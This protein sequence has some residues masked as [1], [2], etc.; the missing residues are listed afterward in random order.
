MTPGFAITAWMTFKTGRLRS[1][2]TEEE[3]ENSLAGGVRGQRT[4]NR[5]S[6]EQRTQ[7]GQKSQKPRRGV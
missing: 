3:P 2:W 1:V 7:E 4:R 6:H 5:R